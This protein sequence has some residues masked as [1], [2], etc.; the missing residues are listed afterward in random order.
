VGA[1]QPPPRGA[2]RRHRTGR[3]LGHRRAQV[4]QRAL[5][6][7]RGH[8]PPFARPPYGDDFHRGIPDPDTGN[9]AGRG[10]LGSRVLAACTRR[11]GLRDACARWGAMAWATSW[12]A[13]ARGHATWPK[14]C[15]RNPACASSTT[16][17]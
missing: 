13:A 3:F 9:G 17:C 4:A 16:S 8:R 1:C 2:G 15:P 14:S 11:A 5:R 7:R 12:I 6:Q 10:R